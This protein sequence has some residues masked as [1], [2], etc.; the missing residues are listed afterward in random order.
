MSFNN[1]SPHVPKIYSKAFNIV[2]NTIICATGAE[3]DCNGT[4]FIPM[5][6]SL[7]NTQC[8]QWRSEKKVAGKAIK[9]QTCHGHWCNHCINLFANLWIWW[10]RQSHNQQLF[11]DVKGR[12]WN[13]YKGYLQD[14]TAVPV[15]RLKDGSTSGGAKQFQARIE[16]ISLAV[17]FA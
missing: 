17:A 5:S 8:T 6:M 13:V 3:P 11:F 7:N 1:L 2:D 4:T 14:S 15:K 9:A 12:F 10:W 16:M